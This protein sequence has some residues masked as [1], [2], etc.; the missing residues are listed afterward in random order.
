MSSNVEVK[1]KRSHASGTAKQHYIDN[2]RSSLTALV[3]LHHTAIGYGGDGNVPY[4]SS[5]HPRASSAALVGFNHLNQA[6]FMGAFFYL[7]GHFSRRA[8]QRKR[9]NL[10]VKDRLFRLGVPTAVYSLVGPPLIEALLLAHHGHQISWHLFGEHLKSLRGVR[11]P[12]WF[13]ATL[14]SFDMVLASSYSFWRDATHIRGPR[15]SRR[16]DAKLLY[17]GL[18]IFSLSEFCFRLIYPIGFMFRLL[19][20]NLGYFLQYAAAYMF[21]AYVSDVEFCVP[22][23][24]TSAG[25]FAVSVLSNSVLAWRFASDLS[26]LTNLSGGLN[27]DA[28]YYAVCSNFTGYLLGSRL[29][30]TFSK[31]AQAPWITFNALAYPAFLVHYPVVFA[32]GLLTDGWQVNSVLKIVA[33]GSANI[34]ASWTLGCICIRTWAVLRA[35]S[36][37]LQRQRNE[38]AT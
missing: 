24:T 3:I 4:R 29:L 7:A 11:S 33:V 15:G 37:V 21:G 23:L 22:S 36:R 13:L 9:R 1:H 17:L 8:L 12:V 5:L 16:V 10:F 34:V 18:S 38:K 32:F 27:I 30:V 19:S 20:L 35:A 14:M 28:A 6:F 31:Y 25:L 2:F 26:V